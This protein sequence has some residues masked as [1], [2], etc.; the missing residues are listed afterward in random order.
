MS[1]VRAWAYYY[2]NIIHT[3]QLTEAMLYLSTAV[4]CVLLLHLSTSNV[5]QSTMERHILMRVG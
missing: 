5:D 3:G 4:H 2:Q 1:G